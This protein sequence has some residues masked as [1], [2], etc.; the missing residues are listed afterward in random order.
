V[1]L[2]VLV[3]GLGLCG[4]AL[5]DA[6]PASDILLGENVFYP[7]DPQVSAA[8]QARLN[9]QVA[10]AHRAH[11]PLKVALI[12]SP[13]D[14]GAIPSF[15]G[16]P[17]QY[18]AFLEREI[19]FSSR[20]PLLVVMPNGYGTAG[21]GATASAAVV[22]ATK[23]ATPTSNGLARA[24]ISVVSEITAASSHRAGSPGASGSPGGGDGPL[25]PIAVLGAC[26]A[27]AAGIIAWRRRSA[28]P[29]SVRRARA[30]ARR[31]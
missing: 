4:G 16:K 10:T 27:L 15:F 11:L 22:A 29:D 1:A 9:A 19:S 23:P 25:L 8:L 12:A 6:D 17:R 20:P 7:Y 18:A 28:P 21:L 13:V 24:A 14:L 3:L 26:I 2:L 30:P 5:G 31:R